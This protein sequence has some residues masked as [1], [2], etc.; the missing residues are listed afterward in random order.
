MDRSQTGYQQCC[1]CLWPTSCRACLETL[2]TRNIASLRPACFL[3][4]PLQSDNG[5]KSLGH[6]ASEAPEG[7]LAH[8]WHQSLSHDDGPHPMPRGRPGRWPAFRRSPF[9]RRGRRFFDFKFLSCFVF[10]GPLT[11]RPARGAGLVPVFPTPYISPVISKKAASCVLARAGLRFRSLPRNCLAVRLTRFARHFR[12]R[13][14]RWPRAH[15]FSAQN[16]NDTDIF[17]PST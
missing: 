2:N 11:L 7:R 6:T 5:P 8:H 15:L 10:R 17:A 12:R 13:L 4:A 1:R 3:G 14:H 16:F 9:P